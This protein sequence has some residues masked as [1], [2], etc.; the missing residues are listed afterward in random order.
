MSWLALNRMSFQGRLISL[1]P[2]LSA[3][4]ILVA[5][6]IMTLHAIPKVS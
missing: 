3:L 5:G 2:A 1:L 4:V 6:L